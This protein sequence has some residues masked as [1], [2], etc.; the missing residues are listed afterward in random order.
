MAVLNRYVLCDNVRDVEAFLEECKQFEKVININF[1]REAARKRFTPN[2]DVVNAIAIDTKEG[3]NKGK[4]LRKNGG[5]T[6]EYTDNEKMY[7]N[8]SFNDH[9]HEF[10]PSSSLTKKEN[11]MPEQKEELPQE[12]PRGATQG[13]AIPM[14][15]REYYIGEVLKSTVSADSCALSSPTLAAKRI[16]GIVDAVITEMNQGE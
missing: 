5:F 4:S 15:L 16:V 1:I 6:I 8:S 13:E 12:S 2:G 9:L 14:S 10:V 11:S 3:C 7:T